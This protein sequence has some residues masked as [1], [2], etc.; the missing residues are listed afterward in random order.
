MDMA[1]YEVRLILIGTVN[2]DG[3]LFGPS[4]SSPK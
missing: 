1:N 4:S 2:A 3:A